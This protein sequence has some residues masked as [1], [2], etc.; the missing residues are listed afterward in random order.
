MK[1]EIF[2]ESEHKLII[3][4][5]KNIYH[6]CVILIIVHFETRSLLYMHGLSGE[7]LWH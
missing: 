4:D 1:G 6:K 3:Q 7:K 2:T 5:H